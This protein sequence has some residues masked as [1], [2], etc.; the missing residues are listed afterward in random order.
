MAMLFRVQ[1]QGGKPYL[2]NNRLGAT[3]A[4]DPMQIRL[5]S[6]EGRCVCSQKSREFHPDSSPHHNF[7]AMVGNLVVFE[8][9]IIDVES[10]NPC[11]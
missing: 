4:S 2:R 1:L 9:P 11:P 5:T 6:A 8:F 3:I 7:S 10:S